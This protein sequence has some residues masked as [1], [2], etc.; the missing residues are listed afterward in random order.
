MIVTVKPDILAF[1]AVTW[2]ILFSTLQ[3]NTKSLE[4]SL[5]SL[6][7]VSQTVVKSSLENV[8]QIVESVSQTLQY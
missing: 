8:F 4:N 2:M 1:S 6:E 7:N 3:L 5:N